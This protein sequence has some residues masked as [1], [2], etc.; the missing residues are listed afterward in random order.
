[1]II[2]TNNS[3]PLAGPALSPTLSLA[4]AFNVGFVSGAMTFPAPD[5]VVGSVALVVINLDTM[6]FYGKTIMA[7]DL[8]SSKLYIKRII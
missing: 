6:F 1:M 7:E 5:A 2:G 3:S 4:S 8:T